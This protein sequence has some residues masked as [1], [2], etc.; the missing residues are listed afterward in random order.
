MTACG[1]W[2][3]CVPWWAVWRWCPEELRSWVSFLL[4]SNQLQ[5]SRAKPWELCN[6]AMGKGGGSSA[7]RV[8]HS[9]ALLSPLRPK[10]WQKHCP[11]LAWGS[12]RG[13]SHQ[14]PL[15][16]AHPFELDLR[17]QGTVGQSRPPL[18]PP[19][20]RK[21]RVEGRKPGFQAPCPRK[22][23]VL[24]ARGQRVH[25]VADTRSK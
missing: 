7:V 16:D 18:L 24:G 3:A 15:P 6:P 22:L 9:V 14:L 2:A 20:R 11:V 12:P 8:G 25:P 19:P 13:S 23:P 17:V 4:P 1:R 21:S 5:G 10:R